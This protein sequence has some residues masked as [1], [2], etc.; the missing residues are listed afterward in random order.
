VSDCCH[1]LDIQEF[2]C[3]EVLLTRF[4]RHQCDFRGSISDS[5]NKASKEAALSASR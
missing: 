1:S 3:I 2:G 5:M 4:R